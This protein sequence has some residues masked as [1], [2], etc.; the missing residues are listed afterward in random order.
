MVSEVERK[1]FTEETQLL[2]YICQ[3][4]HQTVI[5]WYYEKNNKADWPQ[6]RYRCRATVA[7]S[8]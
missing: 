4:N 1:S 2:G 6:R 3:T 8:S 5:F 7:Y